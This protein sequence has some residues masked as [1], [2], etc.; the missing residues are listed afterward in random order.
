MRQN[1]VKQLDELDS[2]ERTKVDIILKL[3]SRFLTNQKAQIRCC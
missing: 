1:R 2:V 3:E